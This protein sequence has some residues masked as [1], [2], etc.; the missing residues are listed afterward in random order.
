MSNIN[1]IAVLTSG[2]DSPGMNAGIRAVI[3]TGIYH[4]KN[5]FGIRRGYDGMVQGDITPMDAKSVANIIQRGGTILKTARSD[6]FRTVEGRKQAYENLKKHNID[7]LVVIGG[8]G[9][10]TG[11]SKFI[12]EF[13]IPIVGMPGTIDNDLNG[14]DFTIGYDTAINTVVEAVD[15]IR[16]TAESHDRLFVVEVMGRDSGL[17]A[18]RSGISTGAEAVLIPELEVDYDAIMKRLDKTRKNKSSRIIIVAEGDKEG[19]MVVAEKIQANF[20]AYDVRLSIL[21]HIQ[22]GGSPTC[23][24]RVL[25]SRL[26]VAAVEGLIEGRKAEMAGLICGNVQFTPFNKAIKHIDKVNE[27]LTRIVEILSL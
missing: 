20:P 10:F 7:A 27:N 6:E 24:D 5:M 18:L 14:T 4:G 13:D 16:D 1:N 9:T 26:G 12:E 15:K 25:A 11:A 21:G 23:M 19:G 2:G 22:R 8:D 3:R 17:I